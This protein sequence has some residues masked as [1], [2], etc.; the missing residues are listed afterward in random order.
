MVG[1]ELPGRTASAGDV[2]AALDGQ[3]GKLETANANGAA[4]LEIVD[5][6]EKRDAKTFKHVTRT[7]WQVWR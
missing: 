5:L 7:W 6:C 3:T 1:V 2:W 4:A